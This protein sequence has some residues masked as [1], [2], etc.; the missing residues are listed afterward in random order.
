MDQS[1]SRTQFKKFLSSKD[2]EALEELWL[3]I[4]TQPILSLNLSSLFVL[5]Q[6]LYDVSPEK[7]LLFLSIL[8]DQVKE[9]SYDTKLLELFKITAEFYEKFKVNEKRKKYLSKQIADCY[10]RLYLNHPNL[11][12]FIRKTE[13]LETESITSAYKLLDQLIALDLGTNIYAPDLG[14]GEVVNVDLLLDRISVK[15]SNEKILIFPL[16]QAIKNLN[17][18]TDND[19]LLLKHRS[20]ESLRQQAKT[21]PL[22]L[23]K[24]L[25]KSTKESLKTAEIKNLLEG[26]VPDRGWNQFWDKIKKLA[27]NDS[28]IIINGSPPTYSHSESVI[29]K[30]AT[31]KEEKFVS[32]TAD[33]KPNLEVLK[34]KILNSNQEEIP[35]LINEIK[36]YSAIKKLLTWIK[37]NYPQAWVNIY[38]R[39]F[40]SN[41]DKRNLD[42]IGVELNDFDTKAF[43]LTLT[44]VFQSYRIY[45][46]Q[47]LWLAASNFQN[48]FPA[49]SFLTRF[50][51]ILASTDMRSYWND[52]KKIIVA[53]KYQIVKTGIPTMSETEIQDFWNRLN[54]LPYLESTSTGHKLEIKKFIQEFYPEFE[55]TEHVESIFSTAEGIAKKKQELHEITNVLIPKSA[56]EIAR[57]R[58]F[59]DLSENY[60]YKAAKEKQARLFAKANAIRADL[61]HTKPINFNSV[62]TDAVNIGTKVTLRDS[63]GTNQEFIIL[64]PYDIDTEHSIIS[65]LAPFA[66]LLLGKKVGDIVNSEPNNE[67]SKTYKI[68]TITIAR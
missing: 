37:E 44:E 67:S 64:G 11:E 48:Q 15:F 63:S 32:S 39:L 35:R 30:P 58:E 22:E 68:V 18:L 65:Y 8:T 56:Q 5:I 53:K 42:I 26:I 36:N 38:S 61:K 60:E 13:L 62:P 3:E 12:S 55:K 25:L 6:S 28:N 34:E 2:F 46:A 16:N 49:K 45:P 52:C 24:S 14:L 19:F 7:G 59:G 33:K 43:S 57:A 41:S 9:T 40:Y 29:Q 17:P 47:F 1:E 51:D 31:S 21:N 4:V 54:A 23:F 66:Q 50:L 10:R 20:P 27:K